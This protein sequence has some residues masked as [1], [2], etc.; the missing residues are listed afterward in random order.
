[1]QDV[2]KGRRS[3]VRGMVAMSTAAAMLVF[4]LP[5]FANAPNPETTTVDQVTV[6]SDGSRTVTV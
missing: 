5:A 6:N 4:A 2:T 3:I 1:M